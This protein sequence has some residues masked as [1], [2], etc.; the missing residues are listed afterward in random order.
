MNIPRKIIN[1]IVLGALMTSQC[2][3]HAVIDQPESN[4]QQGYA[5]LDTRRA[6]SLSPNVAL[7]TVAAAALIAVLVSGGSSNQYR[8]SAH[9]HAHS[10]SH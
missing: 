10:H 1:R 2:G 3:L 4:Y 6:S 7:G 5:Y 8:G 9:S